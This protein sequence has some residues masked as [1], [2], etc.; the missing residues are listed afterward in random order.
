[1]R[2]KNKRTMI[3]KVNLH[4]V[5]NKYGPYPQRKAVVEWMVEDSI[6]N[7]QRRLISRA[8]QA[9]P[10]HFRVS[11]KANYMNAYRWWA[12]QDS[13]LNLANNANPTPLHVTRAQVGK[14]CKTRLKARSS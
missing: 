7:T 10:E 11:P 12:V 9:F 3:E 13:I 1:M 2:N 6:L 5:S 14:W 8:I 4:K